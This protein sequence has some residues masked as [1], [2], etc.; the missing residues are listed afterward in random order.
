PRENLDRSGLS[1][2]NNRCFLRET[3]AFRRRM[4]WVPKVWVMFPRYPLK[5]PVRCPS[6]EHISAFYRCRR[7]GHQR[8]DIRDNGYPIPG[9]LLFVRRR[10]GHIVWG[11]IQIYVR[12]SIVLSDVIKS[13]GIL[14]HHLFQLSNCHVVLKQ[15][16]QG[17]FHSK[18]RRMRSK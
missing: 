13:I 9:I 14:I 16:E 11:Q 5:L 12:S 10:G 6:D 7:S 2:K 1:P 4:V 18:K 15:C 3:F 8:S 17:G